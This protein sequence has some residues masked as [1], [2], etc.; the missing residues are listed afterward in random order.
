M[1]TPKDLPVWVRTV[2]CL[3]A[4]ATVVAAFTNFLTTGRGV[5]VVTASVTLCVGISTLLF[6]KSRPGATKSA[7]AS[8]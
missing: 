7:A 4:C 5:E 2:V 1:A 3:T 8:C 6:R